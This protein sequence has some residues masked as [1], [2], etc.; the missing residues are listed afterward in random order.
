MNSTYKVNELTFIVKSILSKNDQGVDTSLVVLGGFSHSSITKTENIITDP[1]N[2]IHLNNKYKEI[3]I[4]YYPIEFKEEQVK[5]YNESTV[6]GDYLP[7]IDMN[8][9]FG[10][11]I[12]ELLLQL[13]LNNV[14]LLGKCAG[15]GLAI[16]TFIQN[17]KI[18]SKLI[19][20]V[21]ASP[22]N[23]QDI[24]DIIG[25][26]SKQFLFVW[27]SKDEFQFHWGA[28]I[29]ERIKY[30]NSSKENKLMNTTFV[31][32]DSHLHDVPLELFL[33]L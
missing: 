33:Y 15:G 3:L 30:E 10:L 19:L 18:F 29:S 14:H 17:P 32:T 4:I 26:D 6:N 25:L 28:C 16:Q 8:K 27:N 2:F 1:N 24:K 21:P 7:E 23:I 22:N 13:N 12:N 5:I 11:Y 31:T 20:C 9:K